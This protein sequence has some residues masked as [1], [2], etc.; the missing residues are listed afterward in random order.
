M[1]TVAPVAAARPVAGGLLYTLRVLIL[2]H[3]VTLLVAASMA[4]RALTYDSEFVLSVDQ[5]AAEPHVMVGMVAHL[6]GL[7]QLIAAI[8]YWRPGRGAGWPALASLGLFLLGIAQHFV[9]GIGLNV[10]VPNGVL[11]FGLILV[12]LVWSWSPRATVRR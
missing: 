10:H 9:L 2:I 8:L 7:V 1:Q 12:L 5:A 4:G 3:G 6:V 11:L